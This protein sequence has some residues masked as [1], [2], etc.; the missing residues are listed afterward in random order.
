MPVHKFLQLQQGQSQKRPAS[1]QP[2]LDHSF[3]HILCYIQA[4]E[5]K[6][7]AYIL[8]IFFRSWLS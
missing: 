3:C 2:V 4:Q 6:A 1:L 8:G 7:D 5:S